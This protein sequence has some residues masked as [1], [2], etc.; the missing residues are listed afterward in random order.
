[1]KYGLDV[2]ITG[3]YAQAALLADL[4]ALAEASGWDGFFVQDGLLPAPSEAMVDPWLA[5]CAI[6]LATQRLRIGALMTP[7]AAYL[8]WQLARQSVSLDHLCAGRLIFGAGLGFQAA[9]FL[10][11]G[12]DA[13]ARVRAEKL[14][15][16]LALL[17]LFWKGEPFSFAG[18]HYQMR[19]AQFLPTP[20]QTRTIPIWLA[21]VWPH[22]KPLRRAAGFDGLYIASQQATG[23][24]LTPADLH[25]A[26]AYLQ[27]Q[28]EQ[29]IPFDVAFAG[30]TEAAQAAAV[31]QPYVQ[32]GATWW[33]EGIW[34]E[35]GTVQQ[36]RERIRQ[37][38]PRIDLTH[39][40]A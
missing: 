38:P 14:D 27:S 8:P 31:I 36:M 6:A 10:M 11:V 28:R 26:V 3:A 12:A 4:A 37:G 9:D 40:P 29:P 16:G 22:R 24:P 7:M 15:E 30:V 23:E 25:E 13:T 20:V 2:S 19:R 35:R 5:L 21:G 39:A 1:L 34:V 32:A 18:K 17:R 33:L